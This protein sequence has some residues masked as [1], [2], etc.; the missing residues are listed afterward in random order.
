MIRNSILEVAATVL[1][2][3]TCLPFAQAASRNHY[4]NHALNA[5]NVLNRDWYDRSNGQWQDLW[6]NS[7]NMITTLADLTEL[8]TNS[9]LPVSTYYFRTTFAAAQASNGGSFINDFYDDE[10]W[11]AMAWIK[12]YDI[13]QNSTYLDAAKDIFD[14][15]ENGADATC[16]GH[17][18][19]KDNDAN[20]AIGNE[21]YLSVAAS[22]AN[23]VADQKAY[24]EDIATKEVDWFLN[25]GL[26]NENNTINDGLDLSDC[27]PTGTVYTYNQGVILGALIEMNKLTSNQSYLETAS[28]IA[29]GAIDHL[30]DS[31]GILTEP[32]YPGPPDTTGS[33]F[34]GVFARNLAV[35]QSVA[36]DDAY[37]SFLQKNA[38][39]IWSEDRENGG[40]LGPDWQGPY[41][42]ASAAS[43]SSAIDCLIGAAAVP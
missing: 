16:G 12:V 20:T 26:I 5:T 7:A 23:R 37:V 21:L 38:D 13:T 25:S 2:T 42:D 4:I 8:D 33:Q 15:M 43:Q 41:F 10:G 3:T 31:N 19:S 11:W 14:D 28:S 1:L 40:M 27:A 24:Y 30:T 29:H 34:K 6:W 18:W 22:L 32:G 39:A 17:W 9:F 35:L 36:A